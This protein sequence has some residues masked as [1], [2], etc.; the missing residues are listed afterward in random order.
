MSL[1]NDALKRAKQAQKREASAP[2]APETPLQPVETNPAPRSSS[3]IVPACAVVIAGV[4]VWFFVKWWSDSRE[5]TQIATAPSTATNRSIAGQMIRALSTASNVVQSVTN[6][7]ADAE[8]AFG[9]NKL[10]APVPTPTA[11]TSAIVE[12][13][14]VPVP[15]VE[16]IPAAVSAISPATNLASSSSNSSAAAETAAHDVASPAP[17]RTAGPS[18]LQL[19]G[20]FYRLSK[21][22]ALINNRTLYVGDEIEGARVIAITR[23]G[24]KLVAGGKTNDLTLK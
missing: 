20:I 14:T 24:V 9:T 11:T 8:A 15:S 6:L 12:T 13:N 19:Q 7:R 17:V 1:I 22:S 18:P 10:S 5:P 2:S 23:Y 21:P 16:K 4:A 3:W